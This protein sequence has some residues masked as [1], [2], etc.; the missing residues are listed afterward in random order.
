MAGPGRRAALSVHNGCG[1]QRHHRARTVKAH[2]STS[3]VCA[4]WISCACGEAG[5]VGAVGGGCGGWGVSDDGV[6]SGS[7]AAR[8]R[9]ARQVQKRDAS[10]GAPKAVRRARRRAACARAASPEWQGGRRGNENIRKKR[11]K[12]ITPTLPRLS[13]GRRPSTH[14]QC[15]LPVRRGGCAGG[16]ADRQGPGGRPGPAGRRRRGRRGPQRCGPR[17]VARQLGRGARGPLGGLSAR[18]RMAREAGGHDPENSQR[19]RKTMCT[20]LIVIASLACAFFAALPGRNSRKLRV[21]IRS[22]RRSKGTAAARVARRT[23][24]V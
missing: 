14:G 13:S 7:A 24:Q 10:A 22:C 4:P 19:K 9:K 20:E 8:S 1:R 12:T 15:K 11:A 16:E 17:R 23:I 18:L 3:S 21:R 5:S 6:G 2:A